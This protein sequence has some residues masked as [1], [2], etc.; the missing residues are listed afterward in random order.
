MY[1]CTSISTRN[2][3]EIYVIVNL[4]AEEGISLWS[5]SRHREISKLFR[6]VTAFT[7]ID[8]ILYKN[9]K[10]AQIVRRINQ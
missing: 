5:Q 3:V 6:W 9:I 1:Y 2:D 7:D 8:G 4:S 10:I